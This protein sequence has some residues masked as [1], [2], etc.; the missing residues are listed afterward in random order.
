LE[1]RVPDVAGQPGTSVG[2]PEIGDA[3]DVS[4]QLSALLAQLAKTPEAEIDVAAGW[5][6]GLKPGDEVGRFHLQRELG[7]G[8]FGVVYE[9]L[10]RDLGRAVAFKA[11][12][13]GSRIAGR[14]EEWLRREA[15]AVAR[16]NHPNI[17]TLHDF[18][19]G[20]SGPYL[21]FELLRGETLADRL[22]AGPLPLREAVR[23][24]VDVARVLAHAHRA[25][26]VHRDLK[27]ANIFLGQDGTVKVL[28]FGLAYLFGRG[29]PASAGT[30]AYMAPEQW[31]SQP[32]D[33]RTDLFSLGAV[34]HQMISGAVPYRVSRER[35]EALDP[36]PPPKL[37]KS[38]SPAALR[39]LAARLLEKDPTGRPSSA[40]VVLDELLPIQRAVEGELRGRWIRWGALAAA[41]SLAVVG[42]L[43]ALRREP[44]LP[45]GERVLVAVA[46]FN[47]GT[48]DRDL[49]G[50]SGLLITSLEQSQ[51]VQVLTRSRLIGLLRQVGRGEAPRIDEAIGRELARAAGARLLLL[52][53]A[54]RFGTQYALEL[55]ALEP[56]ADRYL[57]SV[58]EHA[59]RKEEIPGALDRLSAGTRRALRERADDIRLAQVRLAE[60]V[61]GNV[62]A[63]Q[64]YFAGTDCMDRPSKGASWI[65]NMQCAPYFRQALAIDPTFALAHYQL[66]YM[67]TVEKGPV[68]E[69]D[70]HMAAALRSLDRVPTKEAG[71]IRAW[72]AHLEGKDEDAA[73]V[74]A[75][76]LADFPQDK[77]TLFL[78]GELQFGRGE[79]A[80][81]V[82]YLEKVLALDASSE[83]PLDYLVSAYGALRRR[84][85]LEALVARIRSSP[86]SPAGVH[87]VVRAYGWLGD[88]EQATTFAREAVEAGGGPAAQSDLAGAMFAAGDYAGFE[89]TARARM[90]AAAGEFNPVGSLAVALVAQGRLDE[91]LRVLDRFAAAAPATSQDDVQYC[92]ALLVAGSAN[93][94]AFWRESAKAVALMPDAADTLAVI[95]ALQRDLAHA[96]ELSAG[97]SYPAAREELAA[98]ETWRRGDPAGALSRLA[99]VEERDP[100]PNRGIVPSY[101]VA[102]VNASLGDAR[103][104]LAAVQRYRS[105]WPRGAWRAWAAP[106]A[107]YLAA[108]AHAQL[109]EH[110]AARQEL[111]KL[112]R[113]STRADPGLP[114]LRDTR[115]LAV[116]IGMKN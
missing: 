40:Q 39:R 15:E 32:G 75:R 52:G 113:Q 110:D 29:G 97:L 82:P 114:L 31:R 55:K 69:R 37:D 9:A 103:A 98:L 24:A 62:E 27:P 45:P 93:R 83:W 47:N 94:D 22:R 59:G 7:R 105:L 21:I 99:A 71:L 14:D 26:V 95:L 35:S 3:P 41:A 25:G 79:Y 38:T 44:P 54:Q 63:Y 56:T 10:D 100:W 36:G 67:L 76:V 65:S 5:T 33:E 2:V 96:T 11:I 112:L 66:A 89:E 111:E 17:V 49:D 104:T 20:P 1:E 90:A 60:S 80:S 57:F 6:P 43:Y 81:A 115:A 92:R 4:A 12:R 51:R 8:G 48:G 85:D 91:G 34:L 30:P 13:P 53:S 77:L 87:A 19:R 109:G 70:A 74:Y 16:L 88:W 18:G 50:L 106:R 102:E 78:A 64:Q 28:D 101:L 73:V 23:V 68:A 42:G 108:W 58:S 116:R 84:A 86:P 46:D 72:K 107:T 61:T